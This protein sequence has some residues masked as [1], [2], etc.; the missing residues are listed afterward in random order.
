[1]SMQ[2][3]FRKFLGQ[4]VQCHTPFGTFQ[5]VVVHTTKHHIIL[6][7]VPARDEWMMDGVPAAYFPRQMPMGPG[8]PGWGGP[9][10]G[11]GWHIAIPIA[12]IIGIT[13]L[14]LHWW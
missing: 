8:G 7:R 10:G 11:G 1:M 13:A 5:G 2:R 14:G 9:G 12:A 6:G 3:Y 4:N